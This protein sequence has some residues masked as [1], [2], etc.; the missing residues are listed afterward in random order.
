MSRHPMIYLSGLAGQLTTMKV[1]QRGR[2]R[3]DMLKIHQG[4][5]L[6]SG[7]RQL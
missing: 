1:A 3:H 6:R 7:P 4:D 2:S 5:I